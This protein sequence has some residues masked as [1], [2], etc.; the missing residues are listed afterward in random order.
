MLYCLI[1]EKSLLQRRKEEKIN[2]YANIFVADNSNVVNV[3]YCLRLTKHFTNV[4]RFDAIR[5]NLDWI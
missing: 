1:D 2:I 4:H 5:Y 3:L